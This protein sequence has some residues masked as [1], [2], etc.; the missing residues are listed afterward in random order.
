MAE[1][2]QKKVAVFLPV[3]KDRRVG[4]I[5]PAEKDS[6]QWSFSKGSVSIFFLKCLEEGGSIF[7]G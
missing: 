4:V 1:W 5:L 2:L 6:A 7:L 3:E